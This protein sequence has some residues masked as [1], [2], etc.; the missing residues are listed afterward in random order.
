M[1]DDRM[2]IYVIGR[3]EYSFVKGKYMFLQ[4]YLYKWLIKKIFW[5]VEENLLYR[6]VTFSSIEWNFRQRR[7]WNI[8]NHATPFPTRHGQG[9]LHNILR[10]SIT[11]FTSEASLCVHI[12]LVRQLNGIS[13]YSNA[14]P[15]TAT[16]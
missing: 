9:S 3:I 7:K 6:Y 11:S 10:R 5:A 4:H 16:R 15:F 1:D 14:T 8:F 12:W 2:D 13:G